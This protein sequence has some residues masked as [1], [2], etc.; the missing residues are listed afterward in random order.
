MKK[1]L[2]ALTMIAAFATVAMAESHYPG[3]PQDQTEDQTATPRPR[4]SVR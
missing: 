1:L 4:A 2:L 3:G